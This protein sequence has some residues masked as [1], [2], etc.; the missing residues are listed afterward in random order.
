MKITLKK[1]KEDDKDQFEAVMTEARE[2]LKEEIVATVTTALETA[3]SAMEA[4]IRAEI[5]KPVEEKVKDLEAKL[6]EKNEELQVLGKKHDKAIKENGELKTMVAN[7]E[8]KGKDKVKES[9]EELKKVNE[10]LD[11]IQVEANLKEARAYVI[12]RTANH[13]M[14][15]QVRLM[16]L[17]PGQIDKG[18]LEFFKKQGIEEAMVRKFAD[19]Q[20]P[21]DVKEAEAR[22]A[23]LERRAI[24]LSGTSLLEMTEESTTETGRA[25]T[26]RKKQEGQPD[27]VQEAKDARFD[28]NFG[29]PRGMGANS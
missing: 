28:A 21:K 20:P 16:V 12:D 15:A 22:F 29:I 23:D 27:P 10:R 7:L 26:G 2:L 19:V 14:K 4:E 9:A 13:P 6:A 3:E 18:V 11:G 8:Q 1:L 24:V 17:G 5:N 25:G